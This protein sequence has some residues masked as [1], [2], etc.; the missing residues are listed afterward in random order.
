MVD[1]V[2][3]TGVAVPEPATLSLL[4]LG[5]VGLLAAAAPKSELLVIVRSSSSGDRCRTGRGKSDVLL[6][7]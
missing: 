7:G 4:V 6:N 5:A 1:N 3:V 2:V